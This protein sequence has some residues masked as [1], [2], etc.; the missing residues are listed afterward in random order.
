MNTFTVGAFANSSLEDTREKL[1]KSI[2]DS[3]PLLEKI[4][5][6]PKLSW[7]HSLEQSGAQNSFSELSSENTFVNQRISESE[8]DH[9]RRSLDYTV[10]N[11]DHLNMA[12]LDR[13]EKLLGE[14]NSTLEDRLH[15]ESYGVLRSIGGFNR[16]SAPKNYHLFLPRTDSIEL[17]KLSRVTDFDRLI[18]ASIMKDPSPR[19]V[20]AGVN[21]LLEKAYVPTEFS[22]QEAFSHWEKSMQRLATNVKAHIYIGDF[23]E[24]N[25]DRA[26]F[27]RAIAYG[28]ILLAKT[29]DGFSTKKMIEGQLEAALKQ[30]FEVK[31]SQY[32]VK[33]SLLREYKYELAALNEMLESLLEMAS[34]SKNKNI[35]KIVAGVAKTYLQYNVNLGE[36]RVFSMAKPKLVKY[37]YR[38]NADATMQLLK[39]M[40]QLHR[41]NR[42]FA[43][44]LTYE[45]VDKQL[46]VERGLNQLNALDS[47]RLRNELGQQGI[48]CSKIKI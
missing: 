25:L 17:L 32:L 23:A 11:L 36:A 35:K 38:S 4:W 2:Q 22:I 27:K 3:L 37:A 26:D 8:K 16:A 31:A 29:E 46:V 42:I 19:A 44:M 12:Q 13:L 20:E 7:A 41:S 45:P 33:D 9:L 39:E 14:I 15:V 18:E 24:A 43:S 21:Y 40:S 30:V 48:S 1:E 28:K 47:Q 5:T 34:Y 10:V 6:S